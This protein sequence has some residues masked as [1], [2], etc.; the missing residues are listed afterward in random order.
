[1]KSTWGNDGNGKKGDMDNGWTMGSTKI[2]IETTWLM[3]W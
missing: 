2:T 1:M 3:G